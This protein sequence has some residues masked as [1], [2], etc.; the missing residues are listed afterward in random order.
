[1]Y[2]LF[3]I[4]LM[5]VQPSPMLHLTKSHLCVVLLKHPECT[6]PRDVS[7]T[8]QFDLNARRQSTLHLSHGSSVFGN[9]VQIWQQCMQ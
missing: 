6:V 5:C 1:M 2:M 7:R 9:I 3:V 8:L 4:C